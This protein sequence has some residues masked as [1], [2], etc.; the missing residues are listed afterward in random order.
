MFESET[1]GRGRCGPGAHRHRRHGFGPG[2]FG[3][4]GGGW[5]RGPR[6][7][8]RKARRGDIR[9][10]ALLLLAEEPRNGY[11]IMQE[12]EERSEGLWRP[13]P[14]SVYPA[15]QQLEDEGLIR[16]EEADGRRLYHLTEAGRAAETWDDVD[17]TW[18]A[19]DQLGDRPLIGDTDGVDTVGAGR[20]VQPPATDRLIETSTRLPSTTGRPEIR[21]WRVNASTSRTDIVGGIVIGSLTTPLSKRLTFATSAACLAGAM[22]LCTTP[23]P[24]SCAIA[25]ARRVS[26]TVSIAADSSGMFSE[27][28]P[29]RRVLRLTSLG[30]TRECAGTSKTSSNVSAFRTTRMRFSYAQ[31]RIIPASVLPENRRWRGV[32]N[33]QQR[34]SPRLSATQPV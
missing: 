34:P 9:T 23:S 12:L 30:T 25:M 32:P 7:R 27:T 20:Q 11:Q 10:A 26:V 1:G 17:R 8:G 29:V 18:N 6:G 19:V 15:L 33:Q 22:F 2:P 14:G 28:V 13:S 21:C 31:K 5:G 16:S 4:L 24:P 3:D